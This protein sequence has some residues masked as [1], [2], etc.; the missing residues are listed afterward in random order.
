LTSISLLLAGFVQN[1]CSSVGLER[2]KRCWLRLRLLCISLAQTHKETLLRA[3]WLWLSAQG[4]RTAGPLNEVNEQKLARTREAS[5]WGAV[6]RP[7]PFN[8]SEINT[9]AWR[10][11]STSIRLATDAT[12][13][14]RHTTDAT[15]P[16]RHTTDATGPNRHTTDPNRQTQSE[17]GRT[18]ISR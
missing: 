2:I 11:L 7:E 8:T 3:G 14:N 17:P 12:G 18:F 5:F 13:P 10:E 9:L 6:Q 1:K 15:G 16:N 4:G